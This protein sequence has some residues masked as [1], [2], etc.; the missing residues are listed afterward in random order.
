MSVLQPIAGKPEFSRLVLLDLDSGQVLR[1]MEIEASNEGRAPLIEWLGPERPFVWSFGVGGPLM[2]DLSV[3]PPKQVRVLP[4]LFGLN[5]MTYPDQISSMGVFYSSVDGGY[6]IVAHVNLP[7]DKSIYLYHGENGQVEK[8]AGD[9]NVM[10]IL[11]GDQ[12]MPLELWQDTPTYDDSYDLV[13]VDAADQ[14]QTPLQV[15]GHIPRKSPNLQSR[16]LPGSKRMLFGSTQGISLVGLPGGETLAFWQLVGA[17]TS[18]LP[19]LSLAPNGRALI[20]VAH[21]N[22]SQIPDSPLYWLSLEK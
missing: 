21:L 17:E 19:T 15:S 18:T 13:R 16:L 7:E 20:A 4:E 2:V 3:D 5:L 1:S 22:D 10:M 12:R 8:L 6:H 9:R 14:P 11:P